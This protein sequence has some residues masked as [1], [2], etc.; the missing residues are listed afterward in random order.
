MEIPK[1]TPEQY[2]NRT[3]SM[4]KTEIEEIS[5]LTKANKA[6]GMRY[7]LIPE[8]IMMITINGVAR[9]YNLFPPVSHSL[10]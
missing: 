9:K 10:I 8:G 4:I 2:G 3:D 5:N 1:L 7:T 6:V